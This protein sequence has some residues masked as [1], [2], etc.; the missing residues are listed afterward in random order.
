M[1]KTTDKY[2]GYDDVYY[3]ASLIEYIGRKT[4]NKRS[5]VAESI[6]KDGIRNLVNLADVN[7]CLSFE[8]VSDEVIKRYNIVRGNFDTVSS[9][10]YQVPS[11]RSIGKVYA[12][13]VTRIADG[14][15]EYPDALFQ[16]LTSSISD[17]L[18]DFNT[19]FYFAPSDEIEYYYRNKYAN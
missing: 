12:N 6:G 9:C 1:K 10:K 11:P 13:L 8:Q 4:T 7:H 14:T 19:S 17:A 5:S 3:A 2:K 16:V 18:S 15:S